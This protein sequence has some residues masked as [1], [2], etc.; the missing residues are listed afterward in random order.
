MKLLNPT[1]IMSAVV[2]LAACGGGGSGDATANPPAQPGNQNPPGNN[3]PPA[4]TAP[5]VIEYYGD[6][7]VWGWNGAGGEQ[8]VA[9]PAPAA[10]AAAL[11]T[12]PQN[13]VRNLGVSGT[14][15]CSL[16]DGTGGHEE[17]TRQM[18]DSDATHVIVN[19]AINDQKYYGVTQYR[20]C[21]TELAT[22]ARAQGKAVVFETPN[23]AADPDVADFAAAMRSVASAQGVPVIDQH[24][25]LL[26]Q[27][28]NR[29]L[30]E[31]VPDGEHPNQQTYIMKGQ[32]AA[33]RFMQLFPR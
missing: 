19:H 8:R 12:S 7:T 11:P 4:N 18:R 28:G 10:F 9:T 6:S 17:W 2:L 29:D 25:Y 14:T 24:A 26:G 31:F 5:Y 22:I 16:R 23:P 30:S 20:T 15:A 1:L 13:V 21:L 27:L 33:Q 3:N 32:Y